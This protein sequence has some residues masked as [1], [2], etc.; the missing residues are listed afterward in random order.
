MLAVVARVWNTESELEVEALQKAILE[1]VSLD[2]P[3]VLNRNVSDLELDCRPDSLQLQ[4][5]WSKSITDV[6]GCIGHLHIWSIFG[7]FDFEENL[8]RVEITDLESSELDVV[9]V[10]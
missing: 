4:E 3:E 1:E 8:V 7:F 10:G 9:N 2:H 5:R 6:S